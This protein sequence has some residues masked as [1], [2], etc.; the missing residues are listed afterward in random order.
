[1]RLVKARNIRR[2]APCREFDGDL[3]STESFYEMGAIGSKLVESMH[4]MP[5]LLSDRSRNL[6]DGVPDRVGAGG[7]GLGRYN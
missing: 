6:P 7:A 4:F 3:H 2:V 5:E 1:M